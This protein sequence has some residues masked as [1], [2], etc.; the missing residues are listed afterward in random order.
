ML[1]LLLAAALP[2]R[3]VP[4]LEIRPQGS[5]VVVSFSGNLESAAQLA[6]PW[7]EITNASNPFNAEAAGTARFFRARENGGIFSST[8]IANL[9]ITGPLQTNFNLAYAGTPDG[10]FPP[11]RLKPYF[12]AQAAIGTLTLPIS[13]R[14]RG[15]SSLQE[16]SFP[17]LKF[18]V[19]KE[20]R[21]GTPFA[22]AREI[23]IGTHCAEGGRGNIGRL[24][25]ERS[26]WREALAY[27]IMG[28]LGFQS[29]RVR[30]A[31][32]EY[33]DTG[34]ADEFGN[35]GWRLSRHA[36]LAEDVELLAD[37]LGGRAL[38]EAEIT[39]ISGHPFDSQLVTGLLLLHA[40]LGNWDFSLETDGRGIW[41]TEV[42]ELADKTLIPI[43]GDFDLAS[44]V[45]ES[46]RLNTPPEYH[47]E[48]GDVERQALFTVTGIQAMAA[49]SDFAAARD[50]FLQN[51]TAI[52]TK[53]NAAEID[54]AGRA[55]ALR[56][57]TAFY[58][59]LARDANEG[60]TP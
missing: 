11:K 51:R 23:K 56:H 31:I 18:K 50:R 15:N 48:L 13:L 33:Q 44:F 12:N 59:A 21:P 40:L 14:V 17:K 25:D 6:G 29:P 36:F 16:C 53:I 60:K 52:E 10:I 8:A 49:R 27:E 34:E 45:T 38:S 4:S 37:R 9:S 42:V 28:Q 1:G 5:Q 19:A 46:V 57:V 58:A 43:A 54:D 3:A 2:A 30:R 47:P 35:S 24:R 20:D 41:N 7:Q 55:N 26:A 32:I 39:A 22:D